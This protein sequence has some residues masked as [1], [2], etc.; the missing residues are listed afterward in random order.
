MLRVT[1]VLT[2]LFLVALLT[3]A[4]APGELRAASSETAAAPAAV[5]VQE[6]ASFSVPDLSLRLARKMAKALA[7]QPG[8][9]RALPIISK[10]QLDI[11]FMAPTTNPKRLLEVLAGLDP[12]TK[13]QGVRAVGAAAGAK[14]QCNGCPLKAVCG[15]N[16]KH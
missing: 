6:I 14:P 10:K 12:A 3:L 1:P 15:G 16:A 9:V 2:A 8:V 11:E 5:A 7:A 4:A 13:L